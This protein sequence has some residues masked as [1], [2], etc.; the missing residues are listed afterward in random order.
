MASAT[1][2][3]N[4]ATATGEKVCLDVLM[5]LRRA[6]TPVEAEKEC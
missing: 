1:G 4:S 3:A 6:K 2:E 5:D